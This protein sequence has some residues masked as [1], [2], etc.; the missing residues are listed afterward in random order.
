MNQGSRSF[1]RCLFW[2]VRKFIV[3]RCSRHYNYK[4]SSQ[5]DKSSKVS[6]LLEMDGCSSLSRNNQQVFTLF[7]KID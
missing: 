5:V 3:N 7:A 6:R 2:E 1:F 4:L